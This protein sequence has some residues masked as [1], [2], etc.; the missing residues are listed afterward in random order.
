[1]PNLLE[2]RDLAVKAGARTLLSD[3]NLDLATGEI[4]ALRGPS[5]T[6]KTTLL[7]TLALLQDPA[8]GSLQFQ[9]EDP[10]QLGYPTWRHHCCYTAQVPAIFP[11]TVHEN[12]TRPFAY[13]GRTDQYPADRA[14][15]MLNTLL[16]EDITP[17]QDADRLSVGQQQRLALVRTLILDPAVL[18]LD[19][20]TSALDPDSATALEDLV[21]QEIDRRQAAA[22]VI[23]HD[24][25][26]TNRWCD[27]IINLKGQP[28]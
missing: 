3:F 16:L 6:G 12:L 18:L 11:G 24:P 17:D 1:M 23:T 10:D 27:R 22:L 19:E 9:G 21:R 7:R 13:H 14:R 25:N 28:A 15:T 26:R 5:G 8:A 2:V 20:P 4:I